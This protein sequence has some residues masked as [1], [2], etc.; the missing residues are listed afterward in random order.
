[1]R[2]SPLKR[3]TPLKRTGTKTRAWESLRRILKREFAAKGVT[4]CEMCGTDNYLSFAHAQK[5][6]KLNEAGLRV[7]ALLCLR[8]HDRI[9]VLPAAEMETEVTTLI[10]KRA[11]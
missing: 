11:A 2:R 10:T 5:R 7:V 4:R 1:M 9:E 6:R 3:K 8:C